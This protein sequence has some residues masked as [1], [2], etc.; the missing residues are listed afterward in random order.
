[1]FLKHCIDFTLV[2]CLNCTGDLI[3]I[4]LSQTQLGNLSFIFTIWPEA[5]HC[6]LIT[7]KGIQQGLVYPP[8]ATSY[9]QY[10]GWSTFKTKRLTYIL[11]VELFHCN[12][13]SRV[14]L[15]SVSAGIGAKE[16]SEYTGNAFTL[17]ADFEWLKYLSWPCIYWFYVFCVFTLQYVGHFWSLL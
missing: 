9:T 2:L 4:M 16:E 7:V 5:L 3:P 17:N 11:A 15:L 8:E 13:L 14:L 10:K 12:N 6:F 1:M